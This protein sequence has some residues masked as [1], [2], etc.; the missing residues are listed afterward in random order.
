[1]DGGPTG[2]LGV[3]HDIRW[4]RRSPQVPVPRAPDAWH[5]APMRLFTILG[6]IFLLIGIG[7]AVFALM[8]GDGSAAGSVMGEGL[9]IVALTFIPMGIIFTVIGVYFGR[10]TAGRKRLLREGIPGQATILS[11]EGGNMVI[12]NIHY[13]VSFRLR[14]M[15]QGRSPYD[16]DHRQLVPIFALASLPV[17]ATVPVMVDPKDPAKLTLDLAG[18]AAGLRL[19]ASPIPPAQVVPNTLSTMRAS[20]NTFTPDLPPFGQSAPGTPAPSMVTVPALGGVTG[21]TLGVVMDQLARSGIS[22]DP[23]VLAMGAVTVSQA[24][25]SIDASPTG[26]AADAALLA[27]GRP[28]T[29]VIR[30]ARDTGIDVHGDSVVELTLDVTPQGGTTYE[31]RTAALIPAAAGSRSSPGA[32]VPV[33]IDPALPDRVAIDWRG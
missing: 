19:A 2:T 22:I 29:A 27:D 3:G 8:P 31:V 17:G 21:A 4:Y 25:T 33:R 6:V 16:V 11:L 28:G 20:P 9:G 24:S 5:S 15:V 7:L 13:L 32:M 23:N 14:V 1:M 18:E 26:Q 30:D 10:L 12:N